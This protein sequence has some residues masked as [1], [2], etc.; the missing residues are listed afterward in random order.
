MAGIGFELRKLLDKDN[1]LGDIRAFLSAALLSSGPWLMSI[2]CLGLLSALEPGGEDR[3]GEIFRTTV[4][5]CY[6]FSLIFVGGFQLVITR[7]LADKLYLKEDEKLLSSF[8][9]CTG[10]ILLFGTLLGI[11]IFARGPLPITFKILAVILFDLIC[12]LWLTMIML[13]AVKDYNSIVIG[14][15]VGSALTLAGVWWLEPIFGLEGRLLGYLLG[16]TVIVF[17]FLAIVLAEFP[18]G[19]ALNLEFI[20]YFKK[21]WELALVGIIYNLAIWVDKFVFWLSADA[22]T[23]VT[24]LVVHD[25]YEGPVF[26]S[27]LSIAPAL[28]IFLVKIE[29]GFYEHYSLYYQTIMGKRTLADIWEQKEGMAAMLRG[30]VRDMFVVQGSITTL[31]I[32]FASD[33]LS[34][35]GLSPTQI[36]LFRVALIGSFLQALMAL[37]VII[38]FYFDLRRR[39]LAVT[40]CYLVLN[41][42]FS[43]ITIKLGFPFYGYGYTY[44]CFCTLM[45]AGYLLDKSL[46]DLEFI[47]FAGQ[48]IA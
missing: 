14:F 26:F 32:I 37:C 15:A 42:L 6:A 11:G 43:F 25:V 31:C 9:T 38:L 2:T 44:S 3:D 21:Y 22:R 36:P 18:T 4:V 1:F 29:T 19:A 28:A 33:I 13:S 24:P 20:T 40:T 47:T 23:I 5:Y 7:Y 45:F 35:S 10:L 16:Q 46:Y 48:P 34:V 41:T 27:Y 30:S 8:V 17:W 39:V 12:V